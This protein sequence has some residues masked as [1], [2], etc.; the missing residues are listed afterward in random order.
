MDKLEEFI[1]TPAYQE[2]EIDLSKYADLGEEMDDD[3]TEIDLEEI[4]KEINNHISGT[5]SKY[6]K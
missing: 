2:N 1:N 4:K 6:F 3:T 5:L